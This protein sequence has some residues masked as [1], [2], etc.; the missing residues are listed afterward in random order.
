M[1]LL[2]FL[3]FL[4]VSLF[5]QKPTTAQTCP[6]SCPRGGPEVKFPFGL[7]AD[8]NPNGHC[9]YPGFGLSCS[10]ET[11]A[12]VVNLPESG[13]FSVKYIDYEAQ[14][15]WI[16]DPDICLPKRFLQSFNISGTPYDSEFWYTLTFFNCSA[17]EVAEARL[18]PISCLSSQNYSVVASPTDISVDSNTTNL[19]SGCRPIRTVKVPFVWYSWWDRV[20]LEWYNPD[21]RLCV[22]RGGDCGFKNRTSQEI[23][24]FNLS[25]QGGRP[26]ISK[27]GIVLGFGIAGFLC[28][29]ALVSITAAPVRTY[30]RWRN[31]PTNGLSPSP[32]AIITGL[33]GR[34]IESYPKT[35]LG[36]SGRL[37]KL[38]DNT[39]PIC[40]S[41][42]Q[43]K[44]TLRTIPTCSHYFHSSCID[45]WL[46]MN[47]SCPLCRNSPGGS[48][49][50]AIT[51]SIS[52]SSSSP[53]ST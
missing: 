13:E 7:N 1:A 43:P 23:G 28:V 11:G 15:I 53:P 9:G 26:R 5:L 2:T 44:E 29:F 52:S 33:D 40:L 21:C 16:D 24:C 51:L 19:Q 45:E 47:A 14:Q 39:C 3:S 6:T 12:L 20:R 48:A 49:A 38:N 41:E 18:M 8:G 50:N 10:N 4:F 25:S 32:A 30:G 34:T 31:P 27:S 17:S 42:Y 46:K 36:E 37:P 22:E 35:E